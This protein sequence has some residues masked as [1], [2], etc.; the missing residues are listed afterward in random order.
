[1]TRKGSRAA[2]YVRVSTDRQT[3]ESQLAALTAVAEA[4]GW[5]VVEIY[6]DAG[7]SGAKGRKDRPG[8][9]GLLKDASRGRFDIVMAWAIDRIGR[10]LV[11]LLSTIQ[12][13]EACQVDLYLDQQAIDTTT[14]TGKLM[15]QVAGAFAEFER[16]MAR[17]RVIAGMKRAKELG[18]RPGKKAIGR[19]L[20]DPAA[21]EKA[22]ALLGEGMGILKVAKTVGLGTGTVQRLKSTIAAAEA[23]RLMV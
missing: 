21:L 2:I 15:Y 9:D 17:Q 7:I 11:D 12:T 18:P 8:L 10:S 1:M 6:Q 4:R 19:P 23:S 5:R 20:N 14:P 13:L 3:V 22:K 16:G